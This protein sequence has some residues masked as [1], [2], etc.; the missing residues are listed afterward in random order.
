MIDRGRLFH[1]IQD[2]GIPRTGS[3]FDAYVAVNN[4]DRRRARQSAGSYTLIQS[5]DTALKLEGRAV[6]VALGVDFNDG[7]GVHVSMARIGRMYP[8]NSPRCGR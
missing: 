4:E 8:P 7:Q 5:Q 1:R 6:L 3:L 2:R